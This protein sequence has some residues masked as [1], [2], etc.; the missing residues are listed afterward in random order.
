MDKLKVSEVVKNNLLIAKFMGGRIKD[1]NY[2]WLPFHGIVRYDLIGSGV[3]RQLQYHKSWDWIM[4]VMA[5]FQTMLDPTPEHNTF[6]EDFSIVYDELVT[7]NLPVMCTDIK[8]VYL[9]V[10]EVI[11]WINKNK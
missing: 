8:D 1:K 11:E 3:G 7:A 4:P 10:V 6:D 2:I 5:K 9:T